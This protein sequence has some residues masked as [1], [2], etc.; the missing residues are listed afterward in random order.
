MY[1]E[2]K[3]NLISTLSKRFETY[4]ER[5]PGIE[6]ASVIK[7]IENNDEKLEQLKAMED[8]GGEIDVISNFPG[9]E[10]I[11]FTDFSKET[12][13]GRRKVCYDDTA[14][15]SRKKHKPD[16]SAFELAEKMG[17]K[18]LNEEQYFALQE[19]GDFDLKSSSWLSTPDEVRS[20]GGAIFGDKRYGRTFIYHNGADSYYSTRGFRAY[21]SF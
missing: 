3:S 5:H 9:V 18:I 11:V 12:P 7:V 8:S 19:V 17:I 4:P 2:E 6:W 1:T 15:E 16:H 13:I 14:R 21:I 10:G 20:L